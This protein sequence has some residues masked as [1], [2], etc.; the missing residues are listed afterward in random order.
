MC[1]HTGTY[2]YSRIHIQQN[3]IV[4]WNIHIQQST[5]VLWGHMPVVQILR[6]LSQE[7]SELEVSLGFTGRPCLKNPTQRNND[8]K[9]S[10]CCLRF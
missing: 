9:E 4:L 5:I 2:I 7:D 10:Y 6:R 3:I 8:R 1:T